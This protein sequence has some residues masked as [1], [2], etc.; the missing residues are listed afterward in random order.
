MVER[1]L[2]L[3]VWSQADAYV[4]L[5]LSVSQIWSR[6]LAS[7]CQAAVSLHKTFGSSS[8]RQESAVWSS[9]TASFAIFLCCFADIT[10]SGVNKAKLQERNLALELVRVTEAAALAAGRWYGKVACLASKARSWAAFLWF[11]EP[12]VSPI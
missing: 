8:P 11:A 7:T 5:V 9:T 12:S 10:E 4:S 2:L 1:S 6:R 3:F